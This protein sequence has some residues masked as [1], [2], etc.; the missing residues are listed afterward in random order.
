[1]CIRRLEHSIA[2][3]FIGI[4]ILVRG[5]PTHRTLRT[6][7]KIHCRTKTWAATHA[8]VFDIAKYQLIHFRPSPFT[9]PKVSM[10]LDGHFVP[11]TPSVKYLGI[12]LDSY[13]TWKP[14]PLDGEKRDRP[15]FPPKPLHTFTS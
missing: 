6:L 3:G 10:K 8:S 9:G 4:A 12:Y 14:Q 13:L 7:Y 15:N 2:A 11:V 1:M 5:S